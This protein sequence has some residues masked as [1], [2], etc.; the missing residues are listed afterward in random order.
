M[1]V[2]VEEYLRTEGPDRGVRE[3]WEVRTGPNGVSV[4]AWTA[5]RFTQPEQANRIAERI[6]DDILELGYSVGGPCDIDA[7]RDVDGD[8]RGHLSVRLHA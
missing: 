4:D 8:W 5:D 2:Q 7:R 6:L 1:D 3:D